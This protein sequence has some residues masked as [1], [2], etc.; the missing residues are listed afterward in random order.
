[1]AAKVG[2][3]DL[4]L[5]VRPAMTDDLGE[6][7]RIHKHRFSDDEYTLGQY[8]L[9][10]IRAFY[11]HFLDRCVF[12]VHV[13]EHGM[14]GFV[15]GGGTKE[16]SDVARLFFWRHLPR[17]CFETLVS[18]RLWPAAL[19]FVLFRRLCASRRKKPAADPAGDV[20]RLLSI[21]VDMSAEGTGAAAALVRAFE[22]R[23][24]RTHAAYELKVA[25]SNLRAVRFYQKV[26][27]RLDDN[28]T[29]THCRFRKEFR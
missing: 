10:M 27:L 1:M 22:S 13:S 24:C 12:L 5:Q 7:A 16:L 2:P 14:D 20:A 26:G 6:V 25:K 11:R 23:V 28:D 4:I 29:P 19:R 21:A 9:P 17:A 8:S 18:P 15:L 3:G